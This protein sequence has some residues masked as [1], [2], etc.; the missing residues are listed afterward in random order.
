MSPLYSS[1]IAVGD[2]GTLGVMVG[3]G[4][5]WSASNI[6]DL[7]DAADFAA[8]SALGIDTIADVTYSAAISGDFGL[9]KLGDNT[10]T[11]TGASTYTGVTTVSRGNLC[12]MGSIPTTNE[13][14][15]LVYNRGTLSGT[16]TVGNVKLFV[17]GA[18]S[19]G[20]NGG[21]DIGT[22]HIHN[23]IGDNSAHFYAQLGNG[24]A[25]WDQLDVE[26]SVALNG[27]D[28]DLSGSRTRLV[29][30]ALLLILNDLEDAIS[31]WFQYPWQ[32]GMI[33]GSDVTVD[34]VKYDVT[35]GYSE[36]NDMALV[37]L[38]PEE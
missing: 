1:G 26:G 14:D 3:G 12:V 19:P 23:F 38:P 25:N 29:G 27:T 5:Q 10:L 4:S 8:G 28:L 2:G 31:G 6:G 34:G 20:A 15:V 18:I 16:G 24:S 7:I 22:L 37:T 30:E 11:L 17:C 21:D 13:R 33:G 36:G 35:Y 32:V 9:T